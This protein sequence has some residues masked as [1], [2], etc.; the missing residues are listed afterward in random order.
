MVP[1]NP[2]RMT[3]L[4]ELLTSIMKSTRSRMLILRK[5]S[6]E[7]NWNLFHSWLAPIRDDAPPMI[8]MQP[9]VKK[10]LLYLIEVSHLLLLPITA[11]T[12]PIKTVSRRAFPNILRT[13]RVSNR[14]IGI[15]RLLSGESRQDYFRQSMTPYHAEQH[16]MIGEHICQHD[17]NTSK[18]GCTEF[19]S[20]PAS[21]F[22]ML[23]PVNSEYR[24][25]S[26]RFQ[27]QYFC[28]CQA[29]LM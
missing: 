4:K 5:L 11:I 2:Q 22:L 12:I 21:A 13:V 29:S 10:A 7:N 8:T 6:A 24:I 17:L 16:P 23:H 20:T 18:I 3:K 25:D 14:F 15:I 26:N 27:L 9:A 28:L 19:K 1:L